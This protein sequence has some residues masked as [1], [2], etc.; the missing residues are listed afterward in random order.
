MGGKVL[1]RITGAIDRPRGPDAQMSLSVPEDWIRSGATLEIEL[2]RN[3][4]CA[5]CHGGGCDGCGRSGAVSLRARR[6][7]SEKVE[8][9]LPKG[10]GKNPESEAPGTKRSVVVRI[11]E[12][13]GLPEH[14]DEL[15]RGNLLLSIRP[16]P[17]PS[18][19]VKRL[20]TPSVPA[21]PNA[22][23]ILDGVEPPPEA[24]TPAQS[25]THPIVYVALALAVAAVVAWLLRH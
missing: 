20:K 23:E 16:G 14:T 4:R 13:G 9:T 3:L 17:E 10:G 18:K 21:P 15:P 12:R 7:D 24:S 8:V 19:G 22:P 2:P 11:P 5:S 25:R 1:G 6:T